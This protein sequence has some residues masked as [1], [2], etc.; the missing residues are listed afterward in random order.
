[1]PYE[2]RK[3]SPKCYEVINTD[4]DKIHAKCTSKK[5]AE[6][7]VRLLTSIKEAP[8]KPSDTKASPTS[9]KAFYGSKIKGKK[10]ASRMEV[11]EFMKEMAK[12]WKNR[13]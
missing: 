7:Q 8:S 6:A 13:K 10:F 1:M 12:E 2:V 3:I 11:N 9:W 5:K 4:T